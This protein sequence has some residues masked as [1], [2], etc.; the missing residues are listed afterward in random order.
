MKNTTEDYFTIG[1]EKFNIGDF[2]Q[3][4][5]FFQA[6]IEQNPYLE[7]GYLKL[8]E[9]YLSLNN[10]RN[11]KKTL[12]R[13]LSINPDNSHAQRL[14]RPSPK[15]SNLCVDKVETVN[16]KSP[17]PKVKLHLQL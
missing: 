5:E 16:Q 9:V 10:E 17:L 3:A 13:L 8:A 1:V 14:L 11:A 15:G 4:M 6:A 12:Y 7:Q 2:K